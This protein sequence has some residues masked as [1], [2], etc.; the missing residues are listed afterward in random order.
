MTMHV[1]SEVIRPQAMTLNA[2]HPEWAHYT[3]AQIAELARGK[4]QEYIDKGRPRAQRAV[5]GIIQETPNDLY[6]P[7]EAI[8]IRWNHED[9]GGRLF[10]ALIK[11]RPV[12][13]IGQHALDQTAGRVGFN[14]KYLHQLQ[15]SEDMRARDLAAHNFNE[16]LNMR[17]QGEKYLMRHVGGLVRGVMSDAYKCLDSRPTTDALLEAVEKEGARL[18]DGTYS[19][20]RCGLK[21]VK[22]VPVELFPNEWAVLGFEYS[23][24]DY[25]DG[26]EDWKA[27]ILRLLCLNGATVSRTY[28]KIHIGKRASADAVLLSEATLR[29]QRKVD[30]ATARDVVRA[31]LG[32]AAVERMIGEVRRAVT[33][34]VAPEAIEGF[35]KTRVNKAE[36]QAIK[37]KFVS[38]DIVEV[39]AGQNAWRFSNAIS[40][41]AKSEEDGRRHMELEKI[42]GEAL[43]AGLA[44]SQKAV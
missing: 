23:N 6:A 24:S 30:A 39:P 41:L 10:Q 27:F 28:R 40:W 7:A 9:E 29:L 15:E 34:P 21:V 42:A 3:P 18:V 2:V 22:A 8:K 26:A 20:T 32:D 12:L 38:A 1:D 25:G 14:T 5:R 11:D 37:D 33:A 35:L 43:S 44:P 36:A 17:P 16:L 13:G 4:L 19:D 31:L